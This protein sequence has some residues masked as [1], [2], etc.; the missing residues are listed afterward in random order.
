MGGDQDCTVSERIFG[1]LGC[2]ALDLVSLPDILHTL[3]SDHQRFSGG[4]LQLLSVRRI[5]GCLMYSEL[6]LVGGIWPSVAEQGEERH[7]RARAWPVIGYSYP[8]LYHRA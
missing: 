3:C 1:N 7:V 8:M 2:T 6:F 5:D 4:R